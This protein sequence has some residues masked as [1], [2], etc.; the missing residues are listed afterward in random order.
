MKFNCPKCKKEFNLSVGKLQGKILRVRCTSCNSVF[1]IKVAGSTPETSS[2]TRPSMPTVGGSSAAT[3]GGDDI[4]KVGQTSYFAVIGK[5]RLGPM[6][7]T[8]LRRL[9]EEGKIERGTLVWHKG[10]ENWKP[11][12]QFMEVQPFFP[13]EKLTPPPMG[14]PPLP[15]S[16]KK[17]TAEDA[18]SHPKPE[19]K[20]D[21]Q[22]K[23]EPKPE[24]P[25]AP[26]ITHD[27][28]GDDERPVLDREIEEEVTLTS[29]DEDFFA[30]G[31][32]HPQPIR[33]LDEIEIAD[34]PL[35]PVELEEQRP[36]AGGSRA[37]LKDF[38][39]M[40][41]LSRK[42]R[43]K[44]VFVVAGI[45]I[46][47]VGTLAAIFIF[48]D[49]LGIKDPVRQESERKDDDFRWKEAERKKAV[50]RKPKKKEEP[51]AVRKAAPNLDD[52]TEGLIIQIMESQASGM[53]DAELAQLKQMDPERFK[54]VMNER[55]V[56]RSPKT[57][58][59]GP[60]SRTVESVVG[61]VDTEDD[62]E[63]SLSEFVEA[64]NREKTG[65]NDKADPGSEGEETD[66]PNLGKVQSSFGSLSGGKRVYKERKVT[67]K[68]KEREGDGLSLKAQISRLVTRKLRAE[69]KSL[70]RCVDNFGDGVSGPL[71]VTLHF[72]P[73]GTVRHVSIPRTSR[74]LER[75]FLQTL[76][77]WRLSVVNRE[78]KL[79]ITLQFQ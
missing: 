43:K 38:S 56:V 36:G 23:P 32:V 13:E 25:A 63:L 66:D 10:L 76:H 2:A 12:F 17:V 64:A 49:P 27:V 77:G 37:N 28:L 44:T 20:Q 40:V 45:I 19:P 29:L 21:V 9:V 68:V 57:N 79:P 42:S 65:T 46:V 15:P 50:E 51:V 26:P 3:G 6:P 78:L 52:D 7:F 35:F 73:D 8:A 60:K 53:T 70:K 69:N 62:E 61:G 5:R 11:A 31:T 59:T 47:A 54:E 14:P 58:R 18:D 22:P 33:G 55:K 72:Q 67:A 34:E 1:K 71:R 41:R 48:G 74:E 4:S 16:Q 75:C 30:A 39:V 24:A